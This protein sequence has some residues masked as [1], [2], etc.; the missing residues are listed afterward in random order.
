MNKKNLATAMAAIVFL[1][2]VLAGAQDRAPSASSNEPRIK[3]MPAQ[4]MLVVESKG[5]P[6]VSAG[7]AWIDPL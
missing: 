4:K 7:N 3:T 5:D 6:S 1:G 2:T